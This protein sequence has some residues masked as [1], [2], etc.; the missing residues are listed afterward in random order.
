M[1]DTMKYAITTLLAAFFLSDTLVFADMQTWTDTA[2]VSIEAEYAGRD[3][4]MIK[5]RDASGREASFK[6]TTFSTESQ[7]QIPPEIDKPNDPIPTTAPSVK[8]KPK[9][10][11]AIDLPSEDDIANFKRDFTNEDGSILR[12]R[13]NIGPKRLTNDEKE[14]TYKSGRILYRITCNFTRI[15]KSGSKT[16]ERNVGGSVN[17]VVLDPTGDTI[18]SK[19]VSL[20]G[21]SSKDGGKSGLFGE[22]KKS[23]K[24]T[25][26]I[27]IE[28]QQQLFGT[29]DTT[30]LKKTAKPI[31]MR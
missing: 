30:D 2:G 4:D 13:A 23:G 9:P 18:F 29:V 17:I 16:V 19:K 26:Y 25:A 7:A 12:F 11:G 24:Y 22:V 14:S 10:V 6:I 21:L 5:L 15:S 3:G 28:Y 1:G 31:W 27:W 20:S 8:A